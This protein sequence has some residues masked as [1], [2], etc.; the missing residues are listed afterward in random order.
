MF[1][2]CCIY[3]TEKS[4]STL[5]KVNMYLYKYLVMWIVPLYLYKAVS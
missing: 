1:Q 3:F 2:D 5:R 4:D